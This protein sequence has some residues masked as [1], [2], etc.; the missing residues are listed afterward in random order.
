MGEPAAAV[1]LGMMYGNGTGVEQNLM[2]SYKWFSV[3]FQASPAGPAKD[4]VKNLL[5]QFESALTPDQ[6]KAAEDAA[7]AWMSEQL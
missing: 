7:V 3:G 5:A 1:Q 2:E 4:Y 6:R